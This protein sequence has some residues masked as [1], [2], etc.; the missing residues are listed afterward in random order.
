MPALGLNVGADPKA[1]GD[2]GAFGSLTWLVDSAEEAGRLNVRKW[3]LGFCVGPLVAIPEFALEMLL[4]SIDE[5]LWF[6]LFGA[7]MRGMLAGLL[8]GFANRAGVSLRTG[9]MRGAIVYVGVSL[10]TAIPAQEFIPIIVPALIS[11]VIVGAI[12]QHWGRAGR[13]GTA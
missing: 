6:Y 12:T 2:T 3:W 10:L 5:N 7:I 4:S 9:T 13:T 8:T 11:G 1:G